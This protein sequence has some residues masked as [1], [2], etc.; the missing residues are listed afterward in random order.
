M[1]YVR[2]QSAAL[3]EFQHQFRVFFCHG[4]IVIV[5]QKAVHLMAGL[6]NRAKVTLKSGNHLFKGFFSWGWRNSSGDEMNF[7]H[8][9]REKSGKSPAS[10]T[11]CYI[12][13]ERMTLRMG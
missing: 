5:D 1:G 4:L 9:L 10:N 7:I 13:Y 3:V 11:V 12:S 8:A 2:P 6:A